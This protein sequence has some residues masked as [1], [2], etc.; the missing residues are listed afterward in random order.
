MSTLKGEVTQGEGLEEVPTLLPSQ[1][2]PKLD[3]TS[4]SQAT[5]EFVNRQGH[6]IPCTF[7]RLQKLYMFSNSILKNI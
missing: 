3:G 1:G 2:V 7:G 4:T 6:M 5:H